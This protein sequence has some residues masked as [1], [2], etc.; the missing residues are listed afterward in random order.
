MLLAVAARLIHLVGILAHPA[1]PSLA[2]EGANAARDSLHG[3]GFKQF[4]GAYDR[5]ESA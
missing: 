4:R 2:A 1:R 3:M 5:L